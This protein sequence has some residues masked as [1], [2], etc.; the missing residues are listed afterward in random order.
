MQVGIG[1][2]CLQIKHNLKAK[3]CQPSILITHLHPLILQSIKL[4]KFVMDIAKTKILTGIYN[5][6]S[7]PQKKNSCHSSFLIPNTKRSRGMGE[8]KG[9]PL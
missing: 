5:N 9:V 4:N 6:F 1:L 8:M 7:I 2:R 3:E